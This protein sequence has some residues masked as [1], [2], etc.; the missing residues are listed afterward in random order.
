MSVSL[1]QSLR[2][3]E[4]SKLDDEQLLRGYLNGD[5][6][7]FEVLFKRYFGLV[8]AVSLRQLHEPELAQEAAQTVFIILARKAGKFRGTAPVS[9]WLLRTARFVCK[10]ILKAKR[11]RE[12]VEEAFEIESSEPSGTNGEPAEAALLEEALQAMS[13]LEQAC[14]LAHFYEG[15]TFK[16]VGEMLGLRE[17]AAQKKVSRCLEK[18]R[19]YLMRRGRQ[20]P[21]TAIP[22]LLQS[23]LGRAVPEQLVQ[24]ALEAFHGSWT[25]TLGRGTTWLLAERCARLLSIRA[26]TIL[27][28]KMSVPILLLTGGGWALWACSHAFEPEKPGFQGSDPRVETLGKEWSRVVMRMAAAK[29]KYTKVPGPTDPEFLSYTADLVYAVSETTR[30]TSQFYSRLNPGKEPEVL[31]EFLTVELRETLKLDGEQQAVLLSFIQKE[32]AQ[33]TTLRESEKVIAKSSQREADQIKAR[34]TRSQQQLFDRVYGADGLC[35]FQFI[36]VNSG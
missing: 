32:L 28:A 1:E 26:W 18:M 36:K 7:A 27:A 31:A 22:V 29:H 19:R 14:V 2:L 24:S 11:R 16:E 8:Y 35:L 12:E 6:R 4:C 9:G 33:R 3:D 25:A 30:I 15:R 34:L 20:T 13:P 5:D 21:Q 17:D 10:D 23:L